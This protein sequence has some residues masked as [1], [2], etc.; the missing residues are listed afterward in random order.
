MNEVAATARAEYEA[1]VS[2][3]DAAA[4]QKRGGEIAI[5]QILGFDVETVRSAV[6]LVEE[7]MESLRVA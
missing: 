7:R 2:G 3:Q 1:V 4:E 6:T 5:A